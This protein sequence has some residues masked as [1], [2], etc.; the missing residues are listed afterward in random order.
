M[1][2][3]VSDLQ[4]IVHNAVSCSFDEN[5][6][7]TL[8]RF[9]QSQMDTV[10]RLSADWLKKAKSSAAMTLDFITDSDILVLKFDL[11]P[12]SSR[13]TAS[14]DLYVDGVFHAS[15]Q[16]AGLDAK[17]AGFQL[18]AGQHRVTV[19]LP[20]SVQLVIREV[21]L[22][23][24][25]SIREVEKSCKLLCLGDSITQGYDAAFTSL[26]YVNQIARELNAEVIDQGIGGHIFH[27]EY[28]DE[29][30][31]QIDPDLI[32]VAYGTN[33][34]GQYETLEEYAAHTGAYLRK[35]AELFPNTKILGILPIFRND[36]NYQTRKLYRPYTM[37]HARQVLRAQYAE[38]GAHVVEETGIAHLP[39]MYAPDFLHPNDLGFSLMVKGILK[40]IKEII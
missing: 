39:Q 14:L 9:T 2:L 19:Y 34:Y 31:R 37:D 12:G 28:I 33:D 36:G 38:I 10:T 18:P 17:M 7:V 20:W 6:G 32:T 30:V 35:L 21:H 40:K 29:S 5:G 11:F 8:C 22:S 25:A 15:K 27:V 26:T 1:K 23:D 16:M 13:Q 24:G 4:K 3:S